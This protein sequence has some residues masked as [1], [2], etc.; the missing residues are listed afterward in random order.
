M[1]GEFQSSTSAST[2]GPVAL[3]IPTNRFETQLDR[4]FFPQHPTRNIRHPDARSTNLL[5]PL[6]TPG[7]INRHQLGSKCGRAV[8]H[9]Q[10]R[11]QPQASHPSRGR[12]LSLGAKKGNRHEDGFRVLRSVL[13]AC[14]ARLSG[15]SSGSTSVRFMFAPTSKT[16]LSGND[17][18][19]LAHKTSVAR[20]FVCVWAIPLQL[21]NSSFNTF[22]EQH[23]LLG[24]LNIPNNGSTEDQASV[25]SMGP[26][27]ARSS[28]IAFH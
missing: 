6:L 16:T 14:R 27:P 9:K 5:P 13:S 20:H 10:P 12:R 26:H 24:H 23:T 2:I 25:A 15:S 21:F 4:R 8:F 22:S 28:P 18:K 3:P 17:P 1:P 11:T 7:S 19:C